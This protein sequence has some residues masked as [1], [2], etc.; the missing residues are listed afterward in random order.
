MESSLTLPRAKHKHTNPKGRRRGPRHK[1]PPPHLHNVILPPRRSQSRRRSLRALSAGP[2]S[3][4]NIP[5][6][7]AQ[8]SRPKFFCKVASEGSLSTRVRAGEERGW[9]GKC[10][11]EGKQKEGEEDI[12]LRDLSWGLHPGHCS[13]F[14][15]L[16]ALWARSRR[17]GCALPGSCPAPLFWDVGGKRGGDGRAR[18]EK[19]G[20]ASQVPTSSLWGGGGGLEKWVREV[21]AGSS[22]R[23]LTPRWEGRVEGVDPGPGQGK[24]CGSPG[25]GG[26]GSAPTLLAEP[27]AW[28]RPALG[29]GLTRSLLWSILRDR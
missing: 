10:R 18:A 1:G 17:T 2:R 6:R 5:H 25:R 26:P 28:R 3:L 9:A 24:R 27:L 19:A 11:A 12:L 23:A 13:P 20:R 16:A 15:I 22:R 4:I 7:V 29:T 8:G 14:S 21:G